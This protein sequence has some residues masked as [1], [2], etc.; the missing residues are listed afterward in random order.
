MP[1]LLPCRHPGDSGRRRHAPD[2]RSLI[3]KGVDERGWAFRN[4]VEFWQGSPDR[5]H[6]RIVYERTDAGW[7]RTVT[8]WTG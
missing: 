1:S 4:R 3:L 2:A 8:P 5:D 6:T 7:A